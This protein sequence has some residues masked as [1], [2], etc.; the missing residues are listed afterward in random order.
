MDAIHVERDDAAEIDQDR[1]IGCSLC[2]NVCPPQAIQLKQKPENERVTPPET[3]MHMFMEIA[4]RRGVVPM[5][6]SKQ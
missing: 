3:G 4:K 6:I 2:V 5:A 1:C